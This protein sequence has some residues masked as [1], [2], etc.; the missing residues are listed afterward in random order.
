MRVPKTS[1]AGSNDK[2]QTAIQFPIQQEV[3][4]RYLKGRRG[5][6]KGIGKTVMV[7]SRE[8][9][10]TTE[11]ALETGQEV[12]V[13]MHWPALLGDCLMKLV[14]YGPV[15]SSD[16]NGTVVKVR[17]YEFRTRGTKPRRPSPVP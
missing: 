15:V 1:R 8:I 16:P 10:F 17:R 11:Q 14:I 12:E 13:T 3:Q 7:A 5:A 2:G 4:Y 6:E 9:K